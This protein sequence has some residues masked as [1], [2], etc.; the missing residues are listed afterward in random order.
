MN[1]VIDEG[2]TQVKLALFKGADMVSQQFFPHEDLIEKIKEVCVRHKVSAAIYSSVNRPSEF[3]R[4]SLGEEV[5]LLEL[6]RYLKFP[7]EN[8]YKSPETLGVDRMALAAGAVFA[9]PNS[10]VLVI[11]AG[12]CVTYDLVTD[13]AQYLGGAISPGLKM[14]L[15][16][17]HDYTARLPLLEPVEP[18]EAIGKTTNESMMIGAIEG[19]RGEILHFVD[20]C[21][22]HYT[23]LQVILTGGDAQ[24]LSKHLKK[25]IF[26][27]SNFLL[28]S[29]NNLLNYNLNDTKAHF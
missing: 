29:L 8:K 9:H 19:L 27:N 25:T 20:L 1:L 6:S 13:A 17:M 12:T 24:H 2:N 15:R 14:R 26:A 7:F 23:N 28:E 10:T 3:L 5:T 18:N 11:D 22:Q 16:S 21:A 4:A